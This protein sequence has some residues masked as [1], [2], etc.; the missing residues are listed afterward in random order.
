[1][2]LYSGKVLAEP[3]FSWLSAWTIKIEN[4]EIRFKFLIN[5]LTAVDVEFSQPFPKNYR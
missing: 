5:D 1:M 2:A 3:P 4:L